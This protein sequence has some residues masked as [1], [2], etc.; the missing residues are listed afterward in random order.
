MAYLNPIGL[1]PFFKELF[2]LRYLASL[3]AL[4]LGGEILLE[5]LIVEELVAV[6]RA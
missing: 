5:V 2:H 3:F 6:L 4:A 1:N